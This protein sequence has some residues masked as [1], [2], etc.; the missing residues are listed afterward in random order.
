MLRRCFGDDALLKALRYRREL[1][2]RYLD[3]DHYLEKVH[4][5]DLMTD[6]YELGVQ[7]QQLFLARRREKIHPFFDD[8]ILR[9]G[10]AIPARRPIHQRHA[11]QVSSERSPGA[12]DRR[13]GGA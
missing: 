13:A 9:A 3:S 10:F 6:T 5:V 2:A 4:I 11:P 12:K 7:R 1:A 8:D